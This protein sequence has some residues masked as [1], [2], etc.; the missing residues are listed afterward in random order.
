MFRTLKTLFDGANARAEERVRET[1]SI[2]LIDQ[3]IREANQGLKAA[4]M[5]LAALTQRARTEERMVDTLTGRITD[6][7]TRAT[8]ALAAKRDKLAQEAAT[9][10]ASLENE[11]ATRLA[12]Q[13][14]LE[15]RVI[16][17]RASVETV[18]RRITDLKQGAIAARA[19][20]VEAGVH[21]K[22]ATTLSGAGAL[23]EAEELIHNVLN[24]D[25]PFEQAEILREIDQDLAHHNVADR[26]ED[27]GFGD[28]TKAT[29]ASV[30]ER[31]KAAK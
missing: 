9:A 4:K 28:R 22:L 16:R 26:L 29:G 23:E 7:E 21:H 10:I 11:R 2:E 1:Y 31:L 19:S 8:E 15:A 14:R 12:T 24:E 6:L 17:L 5:S 25:D 3:K 20:R 30:L 13:E 27:A 18:N